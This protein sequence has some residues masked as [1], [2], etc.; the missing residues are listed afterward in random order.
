M[1]LDYLLLGSIITNIFVTKVFRSNVSLQGHL[2]GAIL[3]IISGLLFK[4]FFK[5]I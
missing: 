1:N 3:G 2:V 4:K 5:C